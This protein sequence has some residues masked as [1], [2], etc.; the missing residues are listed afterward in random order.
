MLVCCSVF[1][2]SFGKLSKFIWSLYQVFSIPT[3]YNFLWRG[4]AEVARSVRKFWAQ[5]EEREEWMLVCCSK[6]EMTFLGD[7]SQDRQ[8][9]IWKEIKCR[10]KLWADRYQKW[11]KTTFEVVSLY[12]ACL[13][14]DEKTRVWWW[15]G[16]SGKNGTFLKW[17]P[18][19]PLPQKAS[20]GIPIFSSS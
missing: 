4:G 17:P 13:K 11:T 6:P 15:R 12:Y 7:Q 18:P 2:G 9:V 3:I 19:P 16:I 14:L 10:C 20:H 1:S 8:K 5:E